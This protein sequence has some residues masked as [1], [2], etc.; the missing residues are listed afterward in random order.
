LEQMAEIC[1]RKNVLICSDEIHC[2][3]VFKG[4]RHV[5]IASLDPEVARRTITLIAPSKTY[6][7]PGLLCSIAIVPDPDLRKRLSHGSPPHFPEVNLLGFTATLAAYSDGQEWLDQALAYLETNRDQVAD[8]VNREMPGIKMCVPE[9]T[10][11]AWLDCRR[12]GIPGNPCSFFLEHARV[13][14]SD[15]ADFGAGGEGFVRLNFA[16]PR[17]TLLE[18]L[19]RMKAAL[20]GLPFGPFA[21]GE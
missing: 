17:A 3:L 6:N 20:A 5:P 16:C 13:G 8:F 1:L 12:R 4:F 21:A 19:D 10:Y 14:L 7:V 11:L 2:D 18:A 9:A 15:G